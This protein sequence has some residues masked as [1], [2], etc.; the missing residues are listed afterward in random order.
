[1]IL[2]GSE[3]LTVKQ[4][5]QKL[6]FHRPKIEKIIKQFNKKGLKI[7]ERGKSPANP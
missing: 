6:G 7:F 1:V 5:C 2:S 4:I 3:E